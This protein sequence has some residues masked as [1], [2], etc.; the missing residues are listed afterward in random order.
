MGYLTT[1]FDIFCYKVVEFS[2]YN[3]VN[4]LLLWGPAIIF[5]VNF[6]N[7]VSFVTFVQTN[8]QNLEDLLKLAATL[9]IILKEINN[10]KV[11]MGF[12]NS[13]S[14]LLVM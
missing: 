13:N 11:C 6:S 5:L 2:S 14:T 12:S 9:D 4:Y 3:L 8:G 10:G 1:H 7:L